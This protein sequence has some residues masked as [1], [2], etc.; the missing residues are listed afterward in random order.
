MGQ[1]E[2][3][4]ALV[5]GGSDTLAMHHFVI[6][7]WNQGKLFSEDGDEDFGS[8]PPAE[9]VWASYGIH[10][11]DQDAAERQALARFE[12]DTGY[13]APDGQV[14]FLA[15]WLDA[16]DG[17]CVVYGLPDDPDLSDPD[18]PSRARSPLDDRT[19]H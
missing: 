7:V 1:P 9:E 13:R 3:Q 8:P 4:C 10:A 12:R 18:D 6:R 2:L 17:W 19:T 15:E 11:E 14:C 16:D 5:P